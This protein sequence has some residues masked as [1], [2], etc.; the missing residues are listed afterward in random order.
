VP[1]ST[2]SPPPPS[3]L[4][5]LQ[6]EQR[7]LSADIRGIE[8]RAA[9]W[10]RPYAAARVLVRMHSHPLGTVDVPLPA[11]GDALLGA[12]EAGLGDELQRHRA[13]DGDSDPPACLAARRAVLADPPFASVVIPTRDRPELAA[14]CVAAVLDSD[15]PPD[16][17]EVL[18]VDNAPT[19]SRTRDAVERAHGGVERVRY[20]VAE[21]AGSGAARNVGARSARGEVVAFLDDDARADPHWLAELLAG[22]RSAPG[23]VCVTGLV[24]AAELDTPAQLLFDRYGGFGYGFQEVVLDVGAHR[25]SNPL[26]PFNPGVLGSGNSV[27]FRREALLELGGYDEVLGNGTPARAGEDWEL[28]LR[29]FR[30]GHTAVYRPTAVV[31]H[32]D[33]PRYEEL[34]A[35]IHDYGVGMAAAVTRTVVHQPVAALELARR[36]PRLLHYVLSSR[37]PKNRNWGDDYPAELRRAEL[38]GL[39]RGPLAYVRS[40]AASRRAAAGG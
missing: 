37:S 38:A 18:V 36:V 30:L 4:E 8:P 40:R 39:A 11:S 21:R 34:R 25:P 28:F 24:V 20:L 35:Q 12:I 15:Y 3:G 5:P 19:D 32:R 7:E 26:F 22:F 9:P 2:D 1:R 16:R 14:G 31:H 6:V 10:G 13:A 33:R 29:L 27:A 17:F 23:V